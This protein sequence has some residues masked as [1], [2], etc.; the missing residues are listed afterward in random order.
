VSCAGLSA[1]H[2]LLA[3]WRPRRTPGDPSDATTPF[4]FSLLGFLSPRVSLPVHLRR[5]HG[6]LVEP[7]FHAPRASSDKPRSS[8]TPSSS[9]PSTE[10]ARGGRNCRRSSSFPR[11]YPLLPPSI[12]LPP[13]LL[14]PNRHRRRPQGEALVLRDP[15]LSFFPR[16]S[17]VAVAT[18]G[19][20]AMAGACPG[21]CASVACE[22]A[23]G[24]SGQ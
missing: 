21:P 4:L 19:S 15:S 18:G 13:A 3:A 8:A 17:A 23:L 11:R 2:L 7:P 20:P 22:W 9:S 10:S 16:R 5:H 1:C 24:P 14:R 12:L 6:C